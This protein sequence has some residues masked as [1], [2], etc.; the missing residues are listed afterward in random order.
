V[1]VDLDG[2]EL[3]RFSAVRATLRRLWRSGGVWLGAGFVGFMF[4]T[5]IT[6]PIPEVANWQSAIICGAGAHLGHI[7]YITQAGPQ[8]AADGTV[9]SAATGV[10]FS[11]H[12]VSSRS[13]SGSRTP[14]VLALQFIGG[15]LVTYLLI[16]LLAVRSS[17]RKRRGRGLQAGAAT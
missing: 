11:Y 3:G 10:G 7:K 6:G 1:G 16:L 13:V 15:T 8:Q 12:C 9:S 5:A 14:V 17:L 4:A 2:T